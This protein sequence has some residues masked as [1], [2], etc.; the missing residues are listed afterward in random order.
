MPHGYTNQTI[1]DTRVVVKTYQGPDRHERFDREHAMLRDL[2][3][4]L[5]V[6]PL[7]DARQ[8]SLTM[9]FVEGIHGQD[10]LDAGHAVPVLRAC[11]LTLNQIHTVRA[12]TLPAIQRPS[13]A[14]GVLVHGDYGPNNLLINP[15]TRQVTA[16]LDW[17]W[18]HWG[19]PI[20]DLAW[21]EWIVRMHHPEH[22]SLLDVFFD[23]YH[24]Q[25]P[26]WPT[27][28]AAMVTRCH[29]LRDLSHRQD[30]TGPG[31]TQWEHRTQIT[32]Q[33]TA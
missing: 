22:V 10:L 3:G 2:Q 24:G 26:P 1:G 19:E 27:R 33:W 14:G 5:P 23:T 13:P 8:G 18:C 32:Q 15:T 29:S 7:I 4:H 12:D 20:E 16:I 25:T 31:V 21:C 6:P 30:P 28:Q 11:G 17:E 9:E